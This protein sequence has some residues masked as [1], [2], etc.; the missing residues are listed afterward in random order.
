VIVVFWEEKWC[1]FEFL[2]VYGSVLD[3]WESTSVIRWLEPLEKKAHVSL[4]LCIVQV[5]RTV[6]TALPPDQD[7]AE[8]P[9]AD[10]EL[11]QYKPEV[12]SDLRRRA[13]SFLENNHK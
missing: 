12:W 4:A 10:A 3:I 9:R 11:G 6:P 1:C 13:E 8:R 7:G 5:L 2:N